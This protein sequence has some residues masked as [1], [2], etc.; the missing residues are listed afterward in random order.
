MLLLG[1]ALGV[2]ML[3]PFLGLIT[4]GLLGSSVCHLGYRWLGQQ[5]PGQSGA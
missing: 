5:P 1:L 3:I 4:P 2:V